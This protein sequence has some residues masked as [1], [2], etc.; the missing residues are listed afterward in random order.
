MSADLSFLG[1]LGLASIVL[2]YLYF[3]SR[4]DLRDCQKN[5]EERDRRFSQYREETEQKFQSLLAER[6]RFRR[7]VNNL[8]DGLLVFDERQRVVMGN[9]RLEEFF[10]LSVDDLVGETVRELKETLE[11]PSLQKILGLVIETVPEEGAAVSKQR[12][13]VLEPE[14]RFLEI[15]TFPL[16]E[17]G[18]MMGWVVM[19]RDVTEEHALERLKAQFAAI[20]AHALRTPIT[21]IKG[22]LSILQDEEAVVADENVAQ[23]ISRA[24]EGI[25]EL[26]KLVEDLLTVTHLEQG[27]INFMPEAINMN[28]LVT[29]VVEEF[30]EKAEEK[31]QNLGVELNETIPPASGDPGMT[32]Q[33]IKILLDNAVRYT[34]VGGEIAVGTF[35]DDE[36][37]IVQVADNGPGIPEENQTLLF[38]KFFRGEKG[39]LIKE[40]EGVGL[41]LYVAKFLIEGQGGTIWAE[42]EAGQG[43]V[44]GF[45]L[46]R[47][48]GYPAKVVL[49]GTGPG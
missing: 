26:G 46:P 25:K 31:Q 19:V 22:Y 11:V 14:K 13:E 38:T 17:E 34:Q 27:R 48:S 32:K 4:R 29:E 10:E 44:F 12:I 40:S 8:V 16:T 5:L 6:D 1:F 21:K 37:V 23:P 28:E 47:F 3:K 45:E 7:V 35:F 43:S 15:I 20:A 30:R 41:G 9:S 18:Q 49:R 36:N 24:Y 39:T 2:G 33:V 42:T